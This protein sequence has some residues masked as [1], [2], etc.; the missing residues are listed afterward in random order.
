MEQ[1]ATGIEERDEDPNWI[2]L[3][4]Y[5]SQEGKERRVLQALHVYLQSLQHIDSEVSQTKIETTSIPDQDWG[6]DWKRFF[7]PLR[8]TSRFVVKPPWS[9]VRL[10]KNQIPI[11][12]HP[13]MAFGTG[14][15]PST[16]LCIKALEENLRRKGFSVLD[17]GTGSGILS[18]VAARLGAREVWGVDIDGVAVENARENVRQNRVSDIVKIRKGRI[19]EI[20]KEFDVVM[21]NLDLKNLK[22]MRMPLLRHL[23]EQG[24]LILSGVLDEERERLRQHYLEMGHFKWAKVTSV[25]GWAC[26]T[27]K[28]KNGLSLCAKR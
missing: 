4:T 1:G 10:R 12:I 22:R 27:L 5:F 15:H 25:D 23:K 3:K 20:R 17:V 24:L 21:A 28:K 13:R 7:R 18:I 26:I 14:T 11:N 6:E 19:G 2:S 16:Q 8:I 9:S